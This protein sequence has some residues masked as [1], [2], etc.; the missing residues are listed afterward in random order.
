MRT[1]WSMDKE[2][3]PTGRLNCLRC[4]IDVACIC[5]EVLQERVVLFGSAQK[6][7][8]GLMMSSTAGARGHHHV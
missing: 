8:L 5:S 1:I 4:H 7:H 2:N 3:K 6:Q